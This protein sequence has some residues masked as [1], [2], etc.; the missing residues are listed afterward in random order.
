VARQVM[1][2]I[3]DNNLYVITHPEHRYGY[4]ERFGKILAAR[5]KAAGL[6]K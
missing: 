3:R 4:E 5:D 6:E 2:A 1:T